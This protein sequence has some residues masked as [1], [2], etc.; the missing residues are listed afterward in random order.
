MHPSREMKDGMDYINSTRLMC[1]KIRHAT[2]NKN[3]PEKVPELI[4]KHWVIED[5]MVKAFSWCWLFC[6]AYSGNAKVIN[7]SPDDVMNNPGDRAAE[8]RTVWNNIFVKQYKDIANPDMMKEIYEK[9][10]VWRY[11]CDKSQDRKDELEDELD[12]LLSAIEEN[13]ETNMDKYISLLNEHK[14]LILTGAPGT[15]KTYLARQI[16]MQMIG[17]NDE[18]ELEKNEQFDFVQFH[19]SYDYTD[20]VEGL[21][22]IADGEN[23]NRN[24]GFE[25][26]NGI[27]KDFCKN[28]LLASTANEVDN[29]SESWDKFLKKFEDEDFL[30]IPLLTKGTFRIEMNE[31]G[32]GLASR[33]YEDNDYSKWIVGKSKFFNR[34]QLY[35]V[36][37]GIP[38]IPS[39]GHDNYRRAIID[40]LKGNCGL[41]DFKAGNITNTDKKYIFVIDEIN[42][43]EVSKIFGE[44]FFSIDPGYRGA[45]GK[46][47]T[48]YANLQN[49]NDVFGG[50]FYVP[51]NVYIIGTMNDID[52]SVES[53]DFAMRRRF[54]WT[55]VT[56]EE[57]ADNMKLPDN[58]KKIMKG[59][60][61]AISKI[62]GLNQSYH[63]GASYFRKEKDKE[64]I[65]PDYDELWELRLEL[66]LRE[67]LR[68]TQNIEGNMKELYK[69]YWGKEPD[70]Q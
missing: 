67:Y 40:F 60:N 55:E 49:N 62:D 53:F 36:Y 39:G 47:K 25:I 35:N 9:S 43:G 14:N 34:D 51:E 65:E 45:K 31:Y 48:Q 68:G 41:K 44:L 4:R 17:I 23:E 18:G 13:K 5:E 30:D 6:W 59:L 38:G 27:F 1:E 21:R 63:I 10:Q 58:T 29:F 61:E 64:I 3:Y 16:A 50:W 70:N 56:A 11:D 22:P 57:S 37:K 8:A 2:F 66:L 46:V 15:G 19:P 32:T 54:V 7:R 12:T 42:R 24:I 20:F 28:A 26:K 33:T 69:A 52:R